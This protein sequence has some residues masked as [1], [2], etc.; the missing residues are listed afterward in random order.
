VVAVDGHH[1]D[2][3]VVRQRLG[4]RLPSYM[5]PAAIIELEK[6]PVSVN[7][8]L[9]RKALPEPEMLPSAEW[10]APRSPQEEALCGLFAEVLGMERVGIEDNF[11]ELGGHSLL[12]TR[13]VS[14][15]RTA[16]GVDLSI[17]SLFE[18]PTVAGLAAMLSHPA[19]R[20]AFE[21]MLSLRSR[22]SRPPL[23][24]I[25]P[26]GGLSWCYARLI[27]YL[28]ADYPLYGLQSRHLTE[29]EFLPQTVEEIAAGYM[30]DIRKV[31]PRGPYCLIGWSFGGLVAQAIAS[32]FQQQGEEV[33]LLALLDSYP[34]VVEQTAV[35]ATRD[36]ILSNIC[37]HLGYEAGDKPVDTASLI[38]FTGR[39]GDYPLEAMVEDVQNSISVMNSFIPQGYDG[40]LILFTASDSDGRGVSGA[41]AWRPYISGEIEVHAVACRHWDMLAYREPSA[42][43]GQVLA[44]RL[45]MNRF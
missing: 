21:V 9:D 22:G 4:Q 19:D 34:P 3:G 17:R 13:L 31:R 40:D 1:I 29:P 18:A 38:E 16:L 30:D 6:L 15:A 45:R 42:R 43:I 27:P 32:L 35:C 33:A 25:H 44:A 26:A 28:E 24:C 41:E 10:R 36:Q 37:R 11:F 7:G 39:V 12:A 8:K 23:F 5:V 2:S 14:Q 20:N